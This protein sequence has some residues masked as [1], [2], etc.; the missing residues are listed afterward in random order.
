MG[1]LEEQ[2]ANW[3]KSVEHSKTKGQVDMMGVQLVDVVEEFDRYMM[4]LLAKPGDGSCLFHWS[5]C[6]VGGTGIR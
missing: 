4:E 1:L 2:N 6:L 3:I 5:M